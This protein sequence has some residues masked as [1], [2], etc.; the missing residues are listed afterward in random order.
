M[1]GYVLIWLEWWMKKD[2]ELVSSTINEECTFIDDF[3]CQTWIMS[4]KHNT[5]SL[6]WNNIYIYNFFLQKVI[7]T[8]MM[9]SIHFSYDDFF[10]YWSLSLQL[11]VYLLNYEFA[12]VV[13]YI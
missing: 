7:W 8:I 10:G 1:D 3:N 2:S 13:L 12:Y 9:K 6:K 11:Y 5:T 4:I